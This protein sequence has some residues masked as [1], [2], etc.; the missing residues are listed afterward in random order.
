M[1]R[2]G[3]TGAGLALLKP[4]RKGVRAAT[5]AELN[6]VTVWAGDEWCGVDSAKGVSEWSNASNSKDGTQRMKEN[7]CGCDRTGERCWR[8]SKIGSGVVS[9]GGE[10]KCR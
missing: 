1:L 4:R 9:G 3:R 5:V 10:K 6:M 8:Y 2:R 7:E